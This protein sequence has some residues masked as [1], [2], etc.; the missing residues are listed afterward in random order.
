MCTCVQVPRRLQMLDPP[1]AGIAGTWVLGTANL[2]LQ[3]SGTMPLE[4]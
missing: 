2:G 3:S 1:E 4:Y